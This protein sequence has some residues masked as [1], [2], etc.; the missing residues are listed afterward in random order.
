[1]AAYGDR[2]GTYGGV[3]ASTRTTPDN[4]FQITV[5]I[6]SS[7]NSEYYRGKYL[8]T[9]VCADVVGFSNLQNHYVDQIP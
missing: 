1:M 8:S 9:V 3:R 5:F 2:T 4:N 6:Y 7:R